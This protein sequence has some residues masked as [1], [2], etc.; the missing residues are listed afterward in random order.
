MM[1]RIFNTPFELSLRA[2]L[3]LSCSNE[4][5]TS[6]M[7]A[8]IDFMTVYGKTFGVS[9]YNLHGDNTYRYSEFTSRLN[10]I[11][12]AVKRIAL[13]KLADVSDLSG[14]LGYTIN[15]AGDKYA[16]SFESEYAV[17]YRQLAQNAIALIGHKTEQEIISI[18]SKQAVASLRIGGGNG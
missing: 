7:I 8:A 3:I 4:A 11:N 9:S 13:D 16:S 2:L 5:K 10:L 17:E 12:Q 6:D 1:I 15:Q 14:K 18:I